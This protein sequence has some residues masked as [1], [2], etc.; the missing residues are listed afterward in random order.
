MKRKARPG[1]SVRMVPVGDDRERLVCPDCGHVQ[2]DN[3]R[4]TVGAVCVWQE[5]VLLCRRAIEPG[6]GLWTIPAGFLEERETIAEGTLREVWEEARAHVAIEG[7]IG[8]YEVPHISQLYLIHHARLLA[9]DIAPGPESEEVA[10]FS[11]D[12]IPWAALAFDSVGWAIAAYRDDPTG[13]VRLA[14]HVEDGA[15]TG[16]GA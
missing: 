1:P 9:P 2:Y 10:L 16:G 14:V 3:P 7:L 13:A 5:T 6:R 15:A 12:A 4:I 8:I 11:W